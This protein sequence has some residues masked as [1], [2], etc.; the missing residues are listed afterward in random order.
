VIPPA[1]PAP[2]AFR[3]ALS[4]VIANP[5]LILAPV[6]FAVVSLLTVGAPLGI[7]AF[8]LVASMHRPS[9]PGDFVEEL[10]AL[11]PTLVSPLAVLGIL[12]AVLVVLLLLSLL[13]AWIRAGVTG[14][15]LAI[16][17]GAGAAGPVPAFHHPGLGA[18]FRGSARRTWGR[19]F[20][21][22][23]LYG[24]ALSCLFLMLAVPAG[25]GV[26]AV[27]S[28]RPALAAVAFVFTALLV[29]PIT[30][31]SAALR[32]LYLVA[33]R[34]VASEDVDALEAV[35]RATSW[36]MASLT[37]VVLTYLL[38]VAGAIVVGAAFQFPRLASQLLAGRSLPLFFAATGLV[39]ILQTLASFAYDLVVTGS[40]VALWPA[41]A[42]GAPPTPSDGG[43]RNLV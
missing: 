3:R 28:D 11:L 20:G 25:V 24:I 1:R 8:F 4:A 33:C 34:L 30:G 27:T 39:V 14:C 31:A 18:V 22:V 43:L 10:Q 36:T 42:A 37:R 13:A 21:L 32:A 15:F 41:L 2:E 40:F 12:A 7:G 38:T 6:S 17:G 5:V 23:N 9:S 19:Y 29:L 16:E 35:A 26:F